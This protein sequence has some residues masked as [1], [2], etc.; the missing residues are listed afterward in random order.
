MFFERQ[1]LLRAELME[2]K[3][4]I[5]KIDVFKYI[6]TSTHYGENIFQ[7]NTEIFKAITPTYRRINY[8]LNRLLEAAINSRIK[9]RIYTSRPLRNNIII[10]T[11]II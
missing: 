2:K 3:T 1:L 9:A 4:I 11:P 5:N 7:R 6:Y 10:Y 8:K